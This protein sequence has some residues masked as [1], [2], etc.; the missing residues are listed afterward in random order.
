MHVVPAASQVAQFATG[1]VV[2][3]LFVP[4]GTYGGVHE[5]AQTPAFI[6][7]AVPGAFTVLH[8]VHPPALQV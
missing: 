5:G 3:R 7:Q 4:V 2:Q 6:T 1:Q 8:F